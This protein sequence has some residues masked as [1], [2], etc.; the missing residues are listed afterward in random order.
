LAFEDITKT[1]DNTSSDNV[2]IVFTA[3]NLD[4]LLRTHYTFIQP[5]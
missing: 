5:Q 3:W 1:L 2:V 4:Y